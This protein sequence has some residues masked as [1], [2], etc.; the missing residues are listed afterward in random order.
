[1]SNITTFILDIS[2]YLETHS[3]GCYKQLNFKLETS[4]QVHSIMHLESTLRSQNIFK[5]L[6]IFVT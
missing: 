4:T 1:M 5:L 3:I 6:F 2:K